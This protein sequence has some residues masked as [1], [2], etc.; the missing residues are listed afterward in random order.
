MVASRPWIR[1]QT[2]VPRILAAALVLSIGAAAGAAAQTALS[3]AP[4][5]SASESGDRRTLSALP[6]NIGRAFLRV[7]DRETIEPLLIGA[8]AAGVVSIFDHRVTASIGDSRSGFSAFG[9]VAGGV[10]TGGVVAGLFVAG[11]LLPVSRFGDATY[12][13]AIATIVAQGYEFLLKAAI[14]RER[15]SGSSSRLGSSFPSGHSATTFALA[16]VL[17]R[18]FGWEAGVPAYAFAS[19]IAASRVR[20]R[21]HYLSDVVAGATLGFISGRTAVRTNGALRPSSAVTSRP[22]VAISTLGS[23]GLL[24]TVSF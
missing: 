21:H 16:S 10:V 23:S 15:P 2:R 7:F 3:T 6:A 9:D 12:D 13:M 17:D 18:H 24:L 5:A 14:G 8:S 19:M 1:R 4:P 11:R 20:G 22:T